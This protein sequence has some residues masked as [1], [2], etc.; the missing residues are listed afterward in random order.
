MPIFEIREIE[1]KV[2]VYHVE[3]E[4]EQDAYD[5]LYLDG[6]DTVDEFPIDTESFCSELS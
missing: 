1:R 2:K 3:A 4:D 6:L 5:Q